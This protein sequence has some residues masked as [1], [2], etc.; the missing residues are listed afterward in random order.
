[1]EPTL[2]PTQYPVANPTRAPFANPTQIPTHK[3]SAQPI[4]NPTEHPTEFPTHEP[5]ARPTMTPISEPTLSPNPQLQAKVVVRLKSDAIDHKED[6][7]KQLDE[8]HEV[9]KEADKNVEQAN[10]KIA[11]AIGRIGDAH[12]EA[13][14]AN[15]QI[16]VAEGEVAHAVQVKNDSNNAKV[17]G[18]KLHRLDVARDA[19]KVLDEANHE[20]QIAHGKIE[21]A[22]G[23]IEGARRVANFQDK[24]LEDLRK[25]RDEAIEVREKAVHDELEAEAMYANAQADLLVLGADEGEIQEAKAKTLSCPFTFT[26]G[27]SKVTVPDGCAFFGVNDVSFKKQKMVSTP[28]VYFC[29]QSLVPVQIKE[30]DLNDLGLEGSI[31]MIEPGTSTEV[32]FYSEDSFKGMRSSFTKDTFKP[33]NSWLFHDKHT[34]N[35]RVKSAVLTSKTMEIPSSCDE[36]QGLH[37]EEMHLNMELMKGRF[38]AGSFF[39]LGGENKPKRS[40]HARPSNL[41]AVKASPSV[42]SHSKS[43]SKSQ[44]RPSSPAHKKSSSSFES[45]M[46]HGR[47]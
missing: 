26:M 3:P 39:G 4:A 30:K 15:Y 23:D 6:A 14:E 18:E 10:I 43:H 21:E 5:I 27:V 9:K 16:Q 38:E 12:I 19:G 20:E 46:R 32:N 8:A 40:A 37:K 24:A 42:G 41:R 7:E 45:W 13:D 28:A 34:A 1:V 44:S 22:A 47:V 25:D 31:S 17:I 2:I 35:D 11:K 36:L 29:T 33:L